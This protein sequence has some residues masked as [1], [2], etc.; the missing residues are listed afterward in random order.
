MSKKWVRVEPEDVVRYD[1]LRINGVEWDVV[2]GSWELGEGDR[3]AA[4]ALKLYRRDENHV[5]HTPSDVFK[6]FGVVVEREELAHPYGRIPLAPGSLIRLNRGV[7]GTVTYERTDTGW[8]SPGVEDSFTDDEVQREVDRY[9]FE[10]LW[11]AA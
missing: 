7:D 1:K 6:L 2:D 5:V 8:Y 4:T 3:E 10:A 9:G 11:P